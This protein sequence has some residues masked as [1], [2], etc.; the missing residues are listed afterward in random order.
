MMKSLFYTP[1]IECIITKVI[2]LFNFL[3]YIN[4]KI[5][6]VIFFPT[7]ITILRC[8]YSDNSLLIK[9]MNIR[10]ILCLPVRTIIN[11]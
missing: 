7:L 1:I 4:I 5:V 6:I 10:S 8:D 9:Y 11:E 2:N 3:I